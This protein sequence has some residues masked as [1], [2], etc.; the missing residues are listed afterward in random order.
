MT[1]NIFKITISL[2]TLV[3]FGCSDAKTEKLI[4]DTEFV[5]TLMSDMTLKEKIGQMTQVDRQFLNDISD[6]SK[7]GLG[8]LSR[9]AGKLRQDRKGAAVVRALCDE[10]QDTFL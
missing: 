5:E 3:L 4:A 8:S 7:Y 10:N 6:I 1:K 2:F 9:G